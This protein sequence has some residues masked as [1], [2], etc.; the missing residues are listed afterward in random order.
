MSVLREASAIPMGIPLGGMDLN[1]PL[2]QMDPNNSPWLLN[3]DCNNQSIDVRPGA[4]IH[5]TIENV[6]TIRQLGVYGGGVGSDSLFAYTHKSASNHLIYNVSTSTESLVHTTG[7]SSSTDEYVSNYNGKLAFVTN[8][9]SS[10]SARY[11][12]GSTWNSWGFTYD[13]G[14]GANPIG[15]LIV[16][17]YRSRVYIFDQRAFYY[18]G[19]SAVSGATTQVD[20]GDLIDQAGGF[21]W[22]AN[23]PIS[24]QSLTDTL[25]IM[26]TQ[27][28][29]VFAYTGSYPGSS[30]WQLQQKFKLDSVLGY[31]TIL[32][33]RNDLWI[34]TKTGIVSLRAL[35]QGASSDDPS[36][37]SPSY[38]INLHW[39]KLTANIGTSLWT[40]NET[41]FSACHWPEKNRIFVL[42]PGKISESG[43]YSSSGATIF[44]YNT[45]TQAWSIHQLSNVLG[46]HVGGITYYQNGVYFYTGNVVMKL[47][48]S[49]F[50][51]ETYNSAGSYSAIPWVIDGPYTDLGLGNQGK[52]V[53]GISP[54]FETDFT[55]SLVGVSAGAD[56]GKYTKTVYVDFTDDIT[57]PY[58]SAGVV[59]KRIKFRM[60]G[61]SD[62][63]STEG[64]KLYAVDA[65]IEPQRS[66]R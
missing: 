17:N 22:A 19:V 52:K 50:K 6:N 43:T 38:P 21:A 30:T 3:V 56:I 18:G 27:G 15:G 40:G 66:I 1:Q 2:A 49:V 16:L 20:L 9:D 46:T 14:G 42:A 33:Y 54:I 5:C 23:F 37:Y 58:Y 13:S 35:L 65:T 62:P 55:A 47:D 34:L 64:L 60:S 32:R 36:V 10:N 51:D 24:Q 61:N 25:L 44:S 45:L 8:T 4:V 28:G 26:G 57:G 29:E 11:W 12:D 31:N 41:Q 39:T 53:Q 59:G 48:P 7:G 63:T